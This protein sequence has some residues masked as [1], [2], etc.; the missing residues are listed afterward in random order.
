[1]PNVN[2]T[3]EEFRC[4]QDWQR[5]EKAQAEATATRRQR[6]EAIYAKAPGTWTKEDFT[7]MTELMPL[8]L[9]GKVPA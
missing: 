6:F 1:M 8:L 4:F 7:F 2:L 9:Q 5:A 3:D